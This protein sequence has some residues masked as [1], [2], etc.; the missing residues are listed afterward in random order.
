VRVL[1]TGGA[2][3]VGRALAASADP[4]IEAVFAGSADADLRDASA[5]AGLF[6]RVRPTHVIHLAAR[7]GGVLANTQRVGDFFRDNLLINLNVLDAARDSRVEKFV[8]ILS[9]C[10]YPDGAP[11]PL[12]E[13]SLHAG[14]PHPS[15]F[16]YAYAKRMLEVQCR[17]YTQQ[18]GLRCICLIPNN[19]YGPHDNFDTESG[20]VIP[21]LIRKIHAARQADGRAVVWGDGS[22]RRE[23]TFVADLAR[24]IWWALREYDG[25]PLNVGTDEEVTI[26]HAAESICRVLDFDPARL[27]WDTRMPSGQPRKP[28][29]TTRFRALSGLRM[30]PIAD[31]IAAT[32]RWYL[33]NYPNVRGVL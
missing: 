20:H 1:I 4:A 13:T 7:V 11:L 15:N 16:G 23:F 6:A 9:S 27:D 31:G 18:F 32:V 30:T 3:M 19:L 26:R 29:D 8:C 2:G 12:R 25:P 5:C 17:A 21:A 24:A 22:P 33:D 14:E 10:V 28:T